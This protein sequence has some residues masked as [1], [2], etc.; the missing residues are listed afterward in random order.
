MAAAIVAG[1]LRGLDAAHDATNERG[2]PL[3]LVHRDVSPQNVIVDV[4]GVARVLDFGIAKAKG[5]LYTTR[6]GT[7]KGKLAYMAPEQL[8]RRPVTRR[9]DVYAAAV[10]LWE[11]LTAKRLFDAETEAETVALVLRAGAPSPSSVV[12]D[13]PAALDKVVARGLARDPARRFATASEMKRARSKR[14]S[15]SRR[16]RR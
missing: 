1:V 4:F 10:V 14:Q 6:D 5:R 9:T 13:V 8:R 7:V 15:R 3:E 16:S 2:E 12:K 11:T